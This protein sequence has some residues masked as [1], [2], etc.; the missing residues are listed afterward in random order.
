M[1]IHTN[2]D[3]VACSTAAAGSIPAFPGFI[4]ASDQATS[5]TAQVSGSNATPANGQYTRYT[6]NYVDASGALVNQTTGTPQ[7]FT[8][9]VEYPGQAL[10]P[11]VNFNV[12]GNPLD[13][14]TSD[15]V[16]FYQK[17]RVAPGKLTGWKRLMGQEVPVDAYSDLVCI[18]GATTYNAE[19]SNLLLAAGG[20]APASAVN[21]ADTCREAAK[22]CNGPQTPQATQPALDLWIPLLF[23]FNLDCRLSIPSVAI[24]YGQRFINVAFNAQNNLVQA[25]PGNLYLQ[26]TVE[27]FTN[28]TGTSAG[29]GISAYRRTVTRQP[30]IIGASVVST[31]QTI[32]TFEL[33]I[34]NI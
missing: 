30:V 19:A 4:G 24:P 20:A 14:Y 13:E 8:R 6:Y 33:Y 5:V 10:F 9:Y 26:L 22:I 1:V 29:S 28:T 17:F 12:N 2:L 11:V 21:N 34:N 25:A 31:A 32:N 15:A 16:I 27:N 18:S 23:W 3:A 7:N